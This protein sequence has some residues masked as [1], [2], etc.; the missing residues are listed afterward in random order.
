MKQCRYCSGYTIA[1]DATNIYCYACAERRE[2]IYQQALEWE[3]SGD[4]KSY[5]SKTILNSIDS[6]EKN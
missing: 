2:K 5:L 3:V 1:D 4:D 6:D